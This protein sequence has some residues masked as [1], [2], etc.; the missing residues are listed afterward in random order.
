MNEGESGK[1]SLY[2]PWLPLLAHV[3][4]VMCVFKSSAVPLTWHNLKNLLARGGGAY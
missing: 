1:F 3:S 2:E 4:E